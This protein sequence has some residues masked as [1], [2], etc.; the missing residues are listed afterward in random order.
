MGGVFLFVWVLFFVFFCF[1]QKI[2]KVS[3]TTHVGLCVIQ[4]R[5]FVLILQFMHGV[6]GKTIGLKYCH[7]CTEK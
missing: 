1:N 3:I 7:L 4:K 2:F 5:K 6:E